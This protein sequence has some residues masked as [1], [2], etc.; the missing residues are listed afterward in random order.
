M[1]MMR[2]VDLHLSRADFGESLG[3]MR[4]WLDH[5]DCTPASFD[6]RAERETGTVLVHV[7]F[8]ED[9]MATAFERTFDGY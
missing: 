8:E 6:T 4:K 1:R 7:E 5:N 3:E 2:A 9:D